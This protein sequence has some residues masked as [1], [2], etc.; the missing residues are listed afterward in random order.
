[1]LR[2]SIAHLNGLAARLVDADERSP[3]H[4]QIDRGSCGSG[5][6]EPHQKG[7]RLSWLA[8]ATT[9]RFGCSKTRSPAHGEMKPGFRIQRGNFA[10]SYPSAAMLPR[11]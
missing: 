2:D 5:K 10:L 4:R 11:R 1:V 3:G 9:I 7:G 6:T 8:T